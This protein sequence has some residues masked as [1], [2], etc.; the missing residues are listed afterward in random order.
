MIQHYRLIEDEG[1]RGPWKVRTVGYNYTVEESGDQRR[2]M[3][4]YHWHP[5]E[6]T[7]I[8]YPHFHLYHGADVARDDVRKAH[9]PT[10]RMAFEEVLRLVI[11]Q[12]GVTPLRDD[13]RSILEQTQSAFE[14]WRTWP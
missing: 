2:E 8:T 3:F 9:F 4:A 10:G 5:D 14:G 1:P 11:T 12:F 13:W 6:R 7:A